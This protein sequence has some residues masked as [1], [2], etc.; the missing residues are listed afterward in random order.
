M[1]KNV[2][3]AY[4]DMSE[5]LLALKNFVNFREGRS[6]FDPSREKGAIGIPCIVVNDGEKVIIGFN[7][8]ALSEL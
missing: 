3:F 6:E 4:Q 7:E 2:Q 1:K 5:N 8:E